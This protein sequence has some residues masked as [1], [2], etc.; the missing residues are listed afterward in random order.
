[1]EV[2]NEVGACRH[3]ERCCSDSLARGARLVARI[4]AIH[5]RVVDGI[6]VFGDLIGVVV[7]D[8]DDENRAGDSGGVELGHDALDNAESVEFVTVTDSLQIEGFPR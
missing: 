7:D 2:E 3:V 5:L 8:A 6:P 1:M 4:C